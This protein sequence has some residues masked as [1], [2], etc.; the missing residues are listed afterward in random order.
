MTFF[1]SYLFFIHFHENRCKFSK[2]N[3]ILGIESSL[4]D[5]M[6][7]TYFVF[8]I[9]WGKLSEYTR[10]KT[11]EIT[12]KITIDRAI[13][14]HCIFRGDGY[15]NAKLS[16]A[17]WRFA[18]LCWNALWVGWVSFILNIKTKYNIELNLDLRIVYRITFY[19]FKIIII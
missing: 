8:G 16:F 15:A 9:S 19:I 17:T 4:I 6:C 1:I 13:V 18:S 10:R 7:T 3:G 14:Y 5:I 11:N 12:T 2:K